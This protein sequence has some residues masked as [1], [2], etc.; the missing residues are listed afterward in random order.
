MKKLIVGNWKMHGNAAMA[1]ALAESVA[2]AAAASKADV[3]VCP[4]ATLLTQVVGWLIGAKVKTGGQDCHAE[5]EGA[6]TGDISAA[7]LKE[8][9]A[10]YVI[11]G[12]SERRAAYGE[13]N[14]EVAEKAAIAMKSGLIPII[15]VGETAEQRKAGREKAVVGRQVKESLPEGAVSSHF[16]LAYE[17][18][19]AIGS[20]RTPTPEDI[21]EMHAHVT[22]VAARHTGLTADKICV[23]YG[24]SV[25]AANA[26]ILLAIDGVGGVLVGGA[27]V[28]AEEFTT[29]LRA[30]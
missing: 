27:S 18:V 14:A 26:A 21:R 19:W 13:T 4:P 15:C 5:A 2:A 16:V 1:H 20:G 30:A 23:L 29:I 12:H 17:P 6:H 9:G 10:A 7:M 3:A 24:G 8:A 25:N 11:V 28:K 22:A